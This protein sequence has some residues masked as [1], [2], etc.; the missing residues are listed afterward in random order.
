MKSHIITLLPGW[1][2]VRHA[3]SNQQTADN[4]SQIP[5]SIPVG[6]HANFHLLAWQTWSHDTTVTLWL[7]KSGEQSCEFMLRICCWSGWKVSNH[8]LSLL[9]LPNNHLWQLDPCW[10]N[11]MCSVSKQ[12]IWLNKNVIKA[13]NQRKNESKTKHA[14]KIA[15][16][17]FQDKPDDLNGTCS[18][19][20]CMCRFVGMG[21]SNGK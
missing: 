12:W 17:H 15:Y 7:L 18:Q 10:Q 14:I 11:C 9:F 1:D 16:E 2:Q 20:E 3:L 8:S 19:T 4:H 5:F 21:T 6:F 13:N